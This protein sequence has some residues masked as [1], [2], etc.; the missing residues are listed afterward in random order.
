[1]SDISSEELNQAVA[2]LHKFPPG[3][4]PFNLFLQ[5]A[6]LVMLPTYE[7]VPLRQTGGG[8]EVLLLKR[9]PDDPLWPGQLHI[10]GTVMRATDNSLEAAY[11]RIKQDELHNTSLSQAV[12][13]KDELHKSKRGS[14]F[15][16][17][18]WAKV[19]AEPKIGTFYQVNNLPSIL[20]EGQAEFIQS[21]A[22]HFQKHKG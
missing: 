16:K 1:M 14:E 11:N 17:I 12:Y 7:L 9:M 2:I 21:A 5:I 19:E 20:I 6:R 13:V 8:V 15:A 3:F 18:Y 10:P 22:E 4:L